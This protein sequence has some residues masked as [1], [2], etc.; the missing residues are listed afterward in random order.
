[1]VGHGS[2]AGED[3]VEVDSGGGSSWGGVIHT[4]DQEDCSGPELGGG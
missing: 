1:M 3:E 2:R 4:S